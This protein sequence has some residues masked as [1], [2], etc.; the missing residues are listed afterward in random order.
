MDHLRLWCHM[1]PTPAPASTASALQ[2]IPPWQHNLC[3]LLGV[4]LTVSKWKLPSAMLLP[5]RAGSLSVLLIH[6]YLFLQ[7]GT[8]GL[9]EFPELHFRCSFLSS[10]WDTAVWLDIDVYLTKGLWGEGLQPMLEVTRMVGTVWWWRLSG[11]MVPEPMTVPPDCLAH[12]CFWSNSP[13]ASSSLLFNP[14]LENHSL[15]KW[16]E[17]SW[18]SKGPKAN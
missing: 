10:H 15:M 4:H 1:H 3:L 13:N 2:P 8:H 16:R 9:F 12:W 11:D 5:V 14:C 7:S 6:P 17:S 18:G